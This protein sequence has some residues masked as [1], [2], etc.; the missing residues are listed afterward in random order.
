MMFW[1]LAISLAVTVSLILVWPL[2]KLQAAFRNYGLALVVAIPFAAM[3]LYQQVG[4]PTGIRVSGTP[5]PVKHAGQASSSDDSMEDLLSRLEQRLMETPDDLQGW[6]ML[7]RSYKTMQKHG[8]AEQALSLAA[9]LA[10][11]DPLVLVELAEARLYTSGQTQING[12]IRQLLERALS[13]DPT[14]QKAL[15]L[16]G[17]AE[18]QAGEDENAIAYW[19]RLV[20]LVEPGSPV[21]ESV[22]EQLN[23]AR[24]RLGQEI[25]TPQQGGYQLT[26]SLADQ[27]YAVPIGA[28]L[29]IIASDP[30]APGP[31]LGVRRV[32]NPTFPISLELNDEHSMMPERL[33]SGADPVRLLARLSL[34]GNPVAGAGDLESP[35]V[36][37]SSG[38]VDVIS[39]ELTARA[40]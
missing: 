29:Y 37:I 14:Q 7:G 9:G 27:S 12:D 38:S 22:R 18:A 34:T 15:W 21:A 25:E 33:V 28:V 40:N 19:Q 23:L 36:S 2:L 17:M 35:A 8:K 5:A 10:P 26:V 4:T 11:N 20:E 39:L 16:L 13:I 32:E 31:P 1:V 6:L 24:Q 30:A 3:F